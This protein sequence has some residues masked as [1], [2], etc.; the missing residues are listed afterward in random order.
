MTQ[1]YCSRNGSP[2]RRHRGTT[3][4]QGLSELGINVFYRAVVGDQS[5]RLRHVIETARDRAS[6]SPPATSGPTLDDLTKTRRR[7]SARKWRCI[8]RRSTV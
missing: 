4:S 2:A 3:D 6:S 1:N 5:G 8:G 7:F